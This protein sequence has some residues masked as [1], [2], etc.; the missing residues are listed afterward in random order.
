MAF[1]ERLTHQN[2]TCQI[3]NVT[4]LNPTRCG[5]SST[6]MPKDR[7]SF[8]YITFLERID[9]FFRTLNPPKMVF[10]FFTAHFQKILNIK[11]IYICYFR[12]KFSFIRIKTKYQC[13][14]TIYH[15]KLFLMINIW[16]NI[17][18]QTKCLNICIQDIFDL[19]DKIIINIH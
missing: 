6:E 4:S 17:S 13:N 7:D 11:E 5:M 18:N 2:T 12:M 14:R 19:I 1:R 3:C 8:D 10:K 9:V 15:Y 16:S